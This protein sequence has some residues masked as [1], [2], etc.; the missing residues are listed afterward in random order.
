L[1]LEYL[2]KHYAIVKKR[3]AY[4]M[5]EKPLCRRLLFLR[6]SVGLRGC[7]LVGLA[8]CAYTRAPSRTLSGLS[9]LLGLDVLSGVALGAG[10]LAGIGLRL[11]AMVLG[12]GAFLARLGGVVELLLLLTFAFK[13]GSTF[14]G[15]VLGPRDIL[16]AAAVLLVLF[17]QFSGLSGGDV[18]SRLKDSILAT[19]RPHIGPI[20]ATLPSKLTTV[21]S[22]LRLNLAGS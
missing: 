10:F 19:M 11:V 7:G 21:P 17:A 12:R 4:A 18:S 9:R 2:I 16:I 14:L 6:R 3:A 8:L 1:S 13:L 22:L 20:E 5:R 15:L